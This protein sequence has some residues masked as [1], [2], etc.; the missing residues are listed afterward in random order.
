RGAPERR[1]AAIPPGAGLT[2]RGRSSTER[3]LLAVALSMSITSPAYTFSTEPGL[4]EFPTQHP[5][6]LNLRW[7]LEP[8][9]CRCP[10]PTPNQTTLDLTT[11]TLTTNWPP[12]ADHPDTAAPARGRSLFPSRA[13]DSDRQ[14]AALSSS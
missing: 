14:R 10:N 13:P 1:A 9:T 5:V 11:T 12:T 6:A 3:V 8:D 2:A 4:R 7:T